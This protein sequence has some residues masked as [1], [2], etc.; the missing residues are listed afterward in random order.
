[1][2]KSS[3]S[4]LFFLLLN[5]CQTY[6]DGFPLPIDMQT[7][8]FPVC[9]DL[10]HEFLSDGGTATP[11]GSTI[12]ITNFTVTKGNSQMCIS[13]LTNKTIQINPFKK[14]NNGTLNEIENCVSDFLIVS[15]DFSKNA[16]RISSIKIDIM[17]KAKYFAAW[18]RQLSQYEVGAYLDQ[19]EIGTLTVS[20][21]KSSLLGSFSGYNFA[22]FAGPD[23]HLALIYDIPFAG[24][25]DINGLYINF[26]SQMRQSN[27]NM[28]PDTFFDDN[29]GATK[30]IIN[31][32][33]LILN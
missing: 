11:K 4:S 19:I 9:S 31:S 6:T 18:I 33:Q 24:L 1:M 26:S 28:I 17:Y 8:S 13:T 30:I 20:Q 12:D 3:R 2:R 5:G 16:A 10:A 29:G 14:R 23:R 7:S 27:E 32:I 15:P 25:T 22:Q 21:N